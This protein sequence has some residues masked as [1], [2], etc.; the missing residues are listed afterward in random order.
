MKK[1][2]EIF[3]N[4]M[5]D[6]LKAEVISVDEILINKNCDLKLKISIDY[7]CPDFLL[8]VYKKEK[9]KIEIYRKKEEKNIG[10]T[11]TDEFSF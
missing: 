1:E 7:P 4:A 2:F 11:Y 9:E 6:A 8:E 5:I 10:N 3:E